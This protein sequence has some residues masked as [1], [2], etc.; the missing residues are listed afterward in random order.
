MFAHFFIDRPIFAS[1]LSI[2]IVLIGSIA[3]GT[4][5]IAQYPEITPPTIEVTASYPGANA[6]TV[7]DTVA[8]PIE[9]EI[10]GV[11]RMLYMESKCT[12][13]GNLKLTITFELG[14]DLDTA[15]VLTQNRV[16][17]AVPKL[18]DIVKQTGVSTKKKS[19]SII[20]TV[21]LFSPPEGKG[22]KPRYDQLYMS[23]YAALQVKDQLAQLPGVGDVTFLGE[24]EYAMRIWLDPERV[25]ER[26]LTA[27]D[28]VQAIKEQNIQ[29]AAGKIGAPPSTGGI[30]F[31]F[32]MSTKGR[33]LEEDEFN[34]IIIKTGDKGEITRL[35][36]VGRAERSAKNSDVSSTL[37]GQPTITL[38]VFQLPGSNAIAT[39]KGI[40]HKMEELKQR[41]PKGLDYRMVYDTTPF[42]EE[43]IHEVFKA[44]RDA[45]ILVAI[46]VLAFLQS[47]RATIIPLVAVPVAIIGTFGVMAMIGFSLNNL[48][49]FGLVLAIGIVVDDAIVVVEAVEHNMAH[50]LAPREATR[51]AL[52]EVAGPV[53]AVALVLCAVFVPC[54]FITGITGQFFRQFAL[55]IAV[56][57]VISAFN[58][59]TLSPALCA[60]LLKPKEQVRDPLSRTLDFTLGWFFRGFNSVFNVSTSIYTSAVGMLLRGSLIGLVVYGGLLFLTYLGFTKMPTGFIP[61][62]DKGYLLV[63][64]QL[65]DGS[66]LERT[67]E[68]MR[69]IEDLVLKTEGVQSTM[70]VQGMSLLQNV[71][72]S[73]WGGMYVI[74]Q[75]FEKRAHHAELYADNIAAKLR[76]S[77]HSQIS[78]ARTS[79]FGAPPV[80]GLGN[81]SG[82][83]LQVEDRG[84]VGLQQLE[85]SANKLA[86]QANTKPGLVGVFNSFSARVPQ[87]FVKIDRA[88]AKAIGVPLS[89]VF[90]ALQIYLGSLY[91]ND[92]TQFARNY[93]VIV[94]AD[95]LFRMRPTDVGKLKVRNKQGGTIPLATVVNI[96]DINGPAI[97][98]RY[99]M[100]PSA[101]VSGGTL[102]GVSSGQ[103]IRE[104]ENTA[105]EVF[106]PTIGFEWTELTLLQKLAGNT[107][108]IV[109][110]LA[111]VLVFLVLAAQ[112]ESWT[113]PLA[114]ILVVP[115]CL[116]C[117]IAGVAMAGDDINIFTQIGF[118]VLVGLASKNAILIVEFAKAER[119]KG[120][121]PYEATVSACKLRLRPII[122]TSFAFILGVVPLALAHGAGAEMRS[123]LGIAVFSGMLGVTVFGIFLTPIFFYVLQRLFPAKELAASPTEAANSTPAHPE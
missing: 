106:P 112:Y 122:M 120:V 115:M 25:A 42:I 15:Q 90:D 102:P 40:E 87:L 110:A 47:W 74:L 53:I 121:P 71:N 97:V 1:V 12:N 104:I 13:D 20:L 3:V 19:P 41:F 88:K 119:E 43:S 31:E 63:D 35:R 91:V 14:T 95:S 79:V 27:G 29:V 26:G 72:N 22:K 59:L 49:L 17:L 100:F 116:L 50:G 62:Q 2:V 81:A 39:A 94:Q 84:D 78:D 7:A 67:V 65:P 37:D 61:T 55:T 5:P 32:T 51:K 117:S 45:I 52:T 4:L 8:S 70:G 58:S 11:E 34:D 21:N 99:K 69:H 38:A 103:A 107:A 16:S 118:V 77:L 54:A 109:F 60:I 114:V 33:L 68:V 123:T 89:N 44:L 6:Q 101:A 28:I 96:Q 93:Q 73:S 105:K 92:F 111:V 64:V 10:N 83:K 66:S 108:M 9:R 56:S 23:N 46:V 18:P 98:T 86:Q 48:T 82:F 30:D 57:T 75:P 80:D 85:A 113:L 24:R 36:D 76:R